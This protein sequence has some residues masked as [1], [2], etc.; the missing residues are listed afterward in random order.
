M[1]FRTLVGWSRVCEI[2]LLSAIP[3]LGILFLSDV[4]AYVD[5][6]P[7]R[8]QY[9]ALVFGLGLAAVFLSVPA[10]GAVHSGRV[11]W[12]DALFAVT[13]LGI[14]T[15]TAV[16]WPSFGMSHFY[17]PVD[18]PVGVVT[19]CLVLEATRRTVGNA[20]TGLAVL[21][22]LFALTADMIPGRLSGRGVSWDHLAIY[23][24]T[25]SSGIIGLPLGVASTVVLAFILFGTVLFMSGGGQIFID[26]SLALVGRH[27]GGPAKAA[28][29]ASSLFGSVSGSAVS[30]AVMTGSLT[31]PLMIRT[32]YTPR[33]SAAIEAVASTGGQLLPPVMGA[34]AFLMADFLAVP[35]A[36]VALAALVP[37]LLFY[38]CLFVQVHLEAVKGGVS[39]L[40]RHQLPDL[41]AAL[42]RSWLLFVPLLVLIYILFVVNLHATKAGLIAAGISVAC[43]LIQR[44]GR[45]GARVFLDV[46]EETGRRMLDLLVITAAAGIVIGTLAVSGASFNFALQAVSLAGGNLFVL[47]LLTAIAGIVLGMGMPTAGVYILLAVLAA[48]ALV[49]LGVDRMAAHL[50]VLYFGMLSMITPPVCLAVFATTAI[51]GSDNMRTGVSAMRLGGASYLIP[52]VFALSPIVVLQEG[53]AIEIVRAIATATLGIGVLGAVF[54]GYLYRRLGIMERIVLGTGCLLLVW[55]D[56]H[57]PG[58]TTNLLAYTDVVGAIIVLG[59][60]TLLKRSA[61][62]DQ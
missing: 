4:A 3:V 10:R 45:L 39:A 28:I 51:S 31:I 49:Q 8:E 20:L 26:L 46:L 27:R 19:V 62:R 5:Y 59:Y 14:G 53:N 29:V 32:G 61:I 42:K 6:A 43:A 16:M 60:G 9:V 2:V 11:P 41:P 15:Y 35:Y 25:D 36:E 7:W 38:F 24:Y 52:F 58:G 50:F 34:A 57:V 17:P 47:L 12:F 54:V 30:N 13:G 44:R 18:V 33:I 21:S 22:I 23:L 37:A 1:R 56:A 40:S 55:P 48:P